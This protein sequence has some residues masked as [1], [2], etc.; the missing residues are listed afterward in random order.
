MTFQ[1]RFVAKLRA[2]ADEYK[3]R[4]DDNV[5]TPGAVADLITANVLMDVAIAVAR[6]A[7]EQP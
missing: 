7:S 5:G 4:A 1:I 2:K 3:K 6:A